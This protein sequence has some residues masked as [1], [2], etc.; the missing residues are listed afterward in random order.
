MLS[1]RK[2]F[3]SAF[4]CVYKG[5]ATKKGGGDMDDSEILDLYFARSE[6]AIVQMT[7]N[8][9]FI[10]TVLPNVFYPTPWTLRKAS[11]IPITPRGS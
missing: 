5:E 1:E 2:I 11:T 8:T 4:F 7:R 10:V 6:Q 3:H 9:D